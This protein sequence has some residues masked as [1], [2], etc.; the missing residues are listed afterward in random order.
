MR[1]KILGVRGWYNMGI[2][3][4][5]RGFSTMSFVWENT[6]ISLGF[7]VALAAFA[8]WVIKRIFRRR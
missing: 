7:L 5:K 6:L 8:I 1:E 2:S 4:K 3:L